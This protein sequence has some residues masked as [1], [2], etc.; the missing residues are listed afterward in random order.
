[1]AIS[2]GATVSSQ[3][4]G[5]RSYSSLSHTVD[6]DTDLLLVAVCGWSGAK[7]REIDGGN[8]GTVTWTKSGESGQT[9]TARN[10]GDNDTGAWSSWAVMDDVHELYMLAAP[11]IGAGSIS[12]ADG[13]NNP[14]EGFNFVAINVIEVATG[15]G[16]NGIRAEYT[17]SSQEI[18]PLTGC[19]TGNL[20]L[21]GCYAWAGA[22]GT[23]SGYTSLYGTL[24]ND[25][26]FRLAYNIVD[27]AS[28]SVLFGDGGW[29]W[30]GWIIEIVEG[31][32]APS[33]PPKGGILTL[34]AGG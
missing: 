31:T 34:G 24:F 30:G 18:G 28:E 4:D 27:A 29:D 22:A 8:I 21:A 33:G 19:T 25:A 12:F 32:A 7:N 15:T 23:P 11:N 5:T 13:S 6:T 2:I 20:W 16:Q 17:E 10:F 3:T 14:S 1:M 9:M 26:G